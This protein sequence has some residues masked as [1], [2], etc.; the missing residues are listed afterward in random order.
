MKCFMCLFTRSL[1][2][3]G[4]LSRFDTL[5]ISFSLSLCSLVKSYIRW[6]TVW[7]PPSQG[8]SGDSI[9]LKRCR[10]DLVHTY[11]Y[12]CMYV[13]R[14]TDTHTHTH[15]H[16]HIRLYLHVLPHVTIGKP[17]SFN[18]MVSRFTKISWWV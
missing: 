1:L 9:I 8:H 17:L 7:F 16:T 10:C 11:I 18:N 6:S 3:T 14:Q 12:T 5:L 4:Q 13:Y 2:F 15:T